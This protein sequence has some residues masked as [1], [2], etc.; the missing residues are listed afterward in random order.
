MITWQYLA[1]FL[2]GDGWITGSKVKG[3]STRSYTVGFT[4]SAAVKEFREIYNFLKS[5]GLSV[6][7]NER[8]VRSEK[9]PKPVLM[10][11]ISLKEQES[12]V[13]LLSKL[14]PHLLIK[15]KIAQEALSYYKQ[16]LDKRG[17]G[18][19]VVSSKAKSSWKR[20]EVSLLQRM[21]QE[22][23]STRAICNELGRTFDSV[24]RKW[25]QLGKEA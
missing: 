21:K 17:V 3:C 16:R 7:W 8:W 22:G 9:V 20:R 19:E 25:H 15:K 13:E 4:Q 12:V 10:A 2:D 6:S 18:L 23:Y 11:N 5:N 1:G 24:N 14:I